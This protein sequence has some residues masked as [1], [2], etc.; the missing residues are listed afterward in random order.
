MTEQQ[1]TDARLWK[2]FALMVIVILPFIEWHEVRPAAIASIMVMVG[3][4]LGFFA[5]V[6]WSDR[7]RA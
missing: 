1:M 5:A 6:A 4:F 3:L 7:G 2:M